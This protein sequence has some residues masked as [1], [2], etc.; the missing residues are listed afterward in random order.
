[1]V[2]WMPNLPQLKDALSTS[3]ECITPH[4]VRCQS[5]RAHS[6]FSFPLAKDN[7]ST[8]DFDICATVTISTLID[9]IIESFKMFVTSANL[10]KNRT[11]SNTMNSF[12]GSSLPRATTDRLSW[13]VLQIDADE[14]VELKQHMWLLQI[15]KLR[16]VI[17][18]L[19][20]T[21]GRL[22]NVKSGISPYVT[23][24]Q[25]IHIWLVQNMDGLESKYHINSTA[26]F[27]K[28]PAA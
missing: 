8:T 4:M 13:G 14:E 20:E 15:R 22:R 28:H 23:A 6:P 1:V 19:S 26:A 16:R 25:C 7:L 5:V 17:N 21:V 9:R 24:C 12:D 10:P 18:R 3:E 11:R 2:L 27:K